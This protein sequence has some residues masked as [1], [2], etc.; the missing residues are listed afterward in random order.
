MTINKIKN[1]NNEIENLKRKLKIREY[2]ADKGI[3]RLII[4]EMHRQERE[5]TWP[6]LEEFKPKP[7]KGSVIIVPTVDLKGKT[8]ISVINPKYLETSAYKTYCKILEH[9]KPDIVV[10]LHAFNP[11]SYQSLTNSHRLEKKNVPPLV[12]YIE[13]PLIEDQVLHGGPPPYAKN[14]FKEHGSY[15]TLEISRNYTEKAKKTLLNIL[16]IIVKS[17]SPQEIISKLTEMYPES[18]K[19]ARELLY[20]YL[21]TTL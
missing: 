3:V 7:L 16:N 21:K 19:K 8:N 17:N 6:I 20:K 12:P 18:M 4:G 13:E 14:K 9:Y 1:L 10:E 15:V 2:H 11:K 5:A